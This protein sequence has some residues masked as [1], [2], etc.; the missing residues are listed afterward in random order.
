MN[1]RAR[2]IKNRN[3]STSS[4][5]EQLSQEEEL[6]APEA[7]RL[8]RWI[9][10]VI[11]VAIVILSFFLGTVLEKTR[12]ESS[13]SKFSSTLN[14]G[15][16][17]GKQWKLGVHLKGSPNTLNKF[18]DPEG[19]VCT[20]LSDCFKSKYF[21]PDPINF[22]DNPMETCHSTLRSI[23]QAYDNGFYFDGPRVIGFVSSDLSREADFTSINFYN[24]C[25]RREDRGKGVAK[26][27]MSDYIKAVTD[28]QVEPGTRVYLGLD[29][30]FETESAV[31]AFAMYAKMGFNRWWEPCPSIYHFDYKI[32]ERQLKMANPELDDPSEPAS[33]R[34][35]FIF[36]MSQMIL[37]RPDTLKQQIRDSRGNV[38][39]HFCMVMLMGADDFGSVGRDIK[40]LVQGSISKSKSK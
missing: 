15:S 21:R 35:S 16:T 13:N 3:N 25:V 38:F 20:I 33:N 39:H 27:M 12:K 34:P 37:R 40:E 30:D 32:M 1:P 28:K 24:V 36:P 5:N 10:S 18:N 7:R 11:I 2:I 6:L 9:K 22:P 19:D 17:E 31:A 14:S 26:A 23:L 8:N 29:V 4:V